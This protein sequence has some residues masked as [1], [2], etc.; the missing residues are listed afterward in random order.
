M[1]LCNH[2]CLLQCLLHLKACEIC[3]SLGGFAKL[4]KSHKNWIE[5]GPPNHPR[6]EC[7]F[8]NPS[9]TWTEH[10]NHNDYQR[11]I[12]SNHNTQRRRG[13]NCVPSGDEMLLKCTLLIK[14]GRLPVNII[15]CRYTSFD[16]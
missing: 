1:A 8:G 6:P 13:V 15:S 5:L 10:S 16:L 14:L 7:F 4:K 2:V 12:T 9:L 3:Y 11:L